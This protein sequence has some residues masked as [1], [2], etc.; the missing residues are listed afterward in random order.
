MFL[1]IR[2]FYSYLDI[3]IWKKFIDVVFLLN[4]NLNNIYNI[5]NIFF[6]YGIVM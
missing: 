4:F 6:K 2:V 1:D 5:E 3:L